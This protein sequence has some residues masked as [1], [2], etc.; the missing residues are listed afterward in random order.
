MKNWRKKFL[1]YKKRVGIVASGDM[2]WQGGRSHHTYNSI[3]GHTLLVG[4]L[5]K[6]VVAFRFFQK[7]VPP[8]KT[9]KKTE[10]TTIIADSP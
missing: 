2:G 9:L 8:A 6:L 1:T 3:S 10:T 5:M 7:Y 4:G